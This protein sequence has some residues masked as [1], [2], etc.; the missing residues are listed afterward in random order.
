MAATI[1]NGSSGTYNFAASN[2]DLLI[3]CYERCGIRSASLTPEHMYSARMSMN[4]VLSS[5]TSRGVNLWKVVLQSVPL[6]Q[7]VATYSVPQNTVMMLDAYVRQ[8]SM[9]S[10]VNLTPTLTTTL[11]SSSV[12]INYPNH[13]LSV[14]DWINMVTYVSVG[15]LIIYGFYQ[16][17]SVPDVNDFTINAGANATSGV[18]GGA[19]PSFTT[20]PNSP[21]V[22]VTLNNH[23]FVAGQTFVVQ[24]STAIGGITL[25][26]SY[27]IV[28]VPTANTFTFTA[29]YAASTGATVSENSGQ[30]QIAGQN[31]GA[32]LIDRILGVLSRTDY[33]SQPNK[34]QQGFPTQYWYDR[35]LNQNF[36]LWQVP[37]SNG[38]YEVQYYSVTQ[39]QDADATMG[40]TPDIPYRFL[41]AFCA[42]FSWHLSRKWAPALSEQLKADYQAAWAEA[43]AEDRERVTMYVTPDLGGYFQ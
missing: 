29:S 7:G 17:V 20:T 16:V 31:T 23:G 28:T 15:G 13:G 1:Q 36:T 43:A 40:Q 25:F 3:E 4:L 26:G 37:D 38:P 27:T 12:N 18:T 14:G 33:A 11:N 21:T 39:M 5:W 32:Q 30:L 10:P 41:E 8:Y 22:T 6:V 2:A 9:N 19:V 34:Q 24:V 42:E 35:T